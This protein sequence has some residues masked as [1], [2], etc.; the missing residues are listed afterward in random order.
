VISTRTKHSGNDAVRAIARSALA[1]AVIGA[2]A[3]IVAALVMQWLQAAGPEAI[4]VL[5]GLALP[6]AGLILLVA[7]FAAGVSG[8]VVGGRSV[9]APGSVGGYLAG[10][11]LG[12]AV[13]GSGMAISVRDALLYLACFGTLVLIGHFIGVALRQPVLGR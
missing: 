8:G 1:A 4:I 13:T 5:I 9:G 3:A 7:P 2:T 11:I 12:L 10:G 6:G